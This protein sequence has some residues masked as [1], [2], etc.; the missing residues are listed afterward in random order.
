M[1][2]VGGSLQVPKNRRSIWKSRQKI[3]LR[4]DCK[5]TTASR[6]PR[7]TRPTNL[8]SKRGVDGVQEW[9][10]QRQI[11]QR[12]TN[13]ATLEI[14]RWRAA[15]WSERSIRSRPSEMNE[16]ERLVWSAL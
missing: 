12:R 11:V 6:R 3:D 14:C 5:W 2:S 7:R 13:A 8:V 16:S 10:T 4:G 9:K 1:K 15:D